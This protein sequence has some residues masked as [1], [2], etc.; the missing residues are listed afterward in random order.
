MKIFVQIASYR[1]LQLIPTIDDCIN[2]AKYPDNLTFCIVWQHDYTE[3]IDKY[4]N[5]PRFKI[6]DIPYQE[7]KGV[8]WAR[9]KSNLEYSGEEY[10]LQ[11]D[12]HTR[13]IKN[14]DEEIINM[15][16]NLKDEKAILTSYPPEYYPDKPREQ[17]SQSLCVIHTHS[18]NNGHTEQRPRSPS[19]WKQRTKPYNAIHVAAGFVFGKGSYIADVAYDPEMYFS[20]EETALALRFYTHGYN[21]YH[22]HKIILWHFYT[23]A[24]NTK[25]W[26]DCSEWPILDKISK[27]RLNCLLKRNNNYNLG[28]YDLGNVRTLEDF[29]NYS[30][31]DYKKNILHLDTIEGKEPP[32]DSSNLDKWSQHLTHV[33]LPIEW[34]WKDIDHSVNLQFIAFI[35]KSANNQEIY[36]E[37]VSCTD[38]LTGNTTKRNFAFKYHTQPEALPVSLI[39]W[40]YGKN[41]KWLNSTTQRITIYK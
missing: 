14:W 4:K 18:F 17:W 1:D 6:L 10:T 29:Q 40:P 30:G 39:I 35:F 41:N 27:D 21:L 9:H 26:D 32:I 12:S 11:I 13:F 24:T 19:G 33:N 34:L 22:P 36:R 15:W 37:D 20:G 25:H 23:R 28:A 5:D 16:K 2:N 7:S 38:I 8:C 3:N 31:I